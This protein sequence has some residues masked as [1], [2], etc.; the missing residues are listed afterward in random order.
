M[1]SII[2][3]SDCAVHNT[4]A[5]PAGECDCGAAKAHSRW[6]TAVY[7]LVCI[8]LYGICMQHLLFVESV[9]RFLRRDAI[10]EHRQTPLP[11]EV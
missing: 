8:R 10:R 3:W 5:Y 4:P 2:H 9:C 6:W 7:H 1:S 11:V